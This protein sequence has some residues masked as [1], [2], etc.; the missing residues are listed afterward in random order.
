[1][2]ISRKFFPEKSLVVWKILHC[3]ECGK[4]SI[5]SLNLNAKDLKNILD[6][7]TTIKKEDIDRIL[8][9]VFSVP[10]LWKLKDEKEK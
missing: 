8:K 10:P 9:D 6:E 7:K 2:S 4:E 3:S 5:V 1:M